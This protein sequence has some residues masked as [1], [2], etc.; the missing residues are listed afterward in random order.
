MIYTKRVGGI[1]HIRI[2]GFH[3]TYCRTT[4]R[5]PIGETENLDWQRERYFRRVER[6][7]RKLD[8]THDWTRLLG[9][10]IK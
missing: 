8:Q 5:G 3:F 1:R 10:D 4:R 9:Y 7:A 6:R 2:L